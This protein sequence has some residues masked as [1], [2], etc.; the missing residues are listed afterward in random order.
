MIHEVVS[1]PFKGD[2]RPKERDDSVVR[3]SCDSACEGLLHRLYPE[4]NIVA[5]DRQQSVSA[6]MPIQ[7]LTEDNFKDWLGERI[8]DELSYHYAGS[9]EGVGGVIREFADRAAES[10]L[11]VDEAIHAWLLGEKAAYIEREHHTYTHV[12]DIRSDNSRIR[13]GNLEVRG[14]DKFDWAEAMGTG[15]GQSHTQPT[16]FRVP[17]WAVVDRSI[18]PGVHPGTPSEISQA[19]PPTQRAKPPHL[20]VG[21]TQMEKP[22]S[23]DFGFYINL[24]ERGEFFADVRRLDEQTIWELHTEEAAELVEDGFIDNPRDLQQIE[25]HLK[26][27]GVLREADSLHG[28][29]AFETIQEQQSG[30]E[31]LDL[32]QIEE[33]AESIEQ[34]GSTSGP[35]RTR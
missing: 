6:D 4:R 11:D 32:S 15:N 28:M 12:L 18:E 29:Q 5:L 7:T 26:S 34:Q 3:V 21:E 19:N 14:L 8:N 2:G 33:H 17:Y 23:Q 16:Y 22:M 35:V 24:D 1:E 9:E 20:K 25:K 27:V 31:D 30:L 10:G 13:D